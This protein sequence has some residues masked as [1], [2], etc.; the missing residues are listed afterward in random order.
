L[1]IFFPLSLSPSP[2]G[3][4]KCQSGADLASVLAAFLAASREFASL[5]AGDEF[6]VLAAWETKVSVPLALDLI[7]PA[8]ADLVAS[9]SEGGGVC[10]A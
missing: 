8:V 1:N 9:S 10:W 3:T 2:S 6:Y 5:N 7:S 4:S